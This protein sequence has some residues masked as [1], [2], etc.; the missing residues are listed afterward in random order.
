LDIPPRC[1]LSNIQIVLMDKSAVGAGH[2]PGNLLRA[3]NL[4]HLVYADSQ[5]LGQLV[6]GDDHCNISSTSHAYEATHP[7]ER[8]VIDGQAVPI[9]EVL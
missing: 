8:A 6:S 9:R 1:D 4:E 7:N 5:S 2:R 3:R